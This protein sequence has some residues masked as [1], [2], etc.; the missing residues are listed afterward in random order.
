MTDLAA[1]GLRFDTYGGPEAIRTLDQV[2]DKSGRAETATG[3]LAR[4]QERAAAT[5]R[6]FA[7]ALGL[8]GVGTVAAAILGL[9]TATLEYSGA[10]AEVSTLVD[11]TAVSMGDLS[12][13]AI[14]QAGAFNSSPLLQTQA[15]YQ[16]ISAGAS[17]AATATEQLTAANKLA[18]GGVTTVAIAADGLT[19]I[20][21]AYGPKVAGA[22]AVSDAM[23]VAMRAG[24]TTVEQLS[25]SLGQVS[26][27]AAQVGVS[28]D[29]LAAA[30]A[31][32]T[33][34]GIST[35]VA[36]TGLRAILAAVARPSA[37]AT[38]LAGA[39]GL[40]FNSAALQ[41]KGLSGF[42]ADLN[43]A[44][45]GNV[46]QLGMLFGGVEALV[47]MLALAGTA[48]EDF[49][50][51]MEQMGVKAGA[52]DEAFGKIASG[53]AFQVGRIFSTLGAN[54]LSAGDSIL[55]ILAPAIR[56][57][58]SILQGAYPHAEALNTI[59]GLLGAAMGVVAVRGVI[60]LTSAMT[61]QV[62]AAILASA[63]VRAYAA[64]V[65]LVGPASATA[66]AAVS[67][68]TAT[69]RGAVALMLGPWGIAIA[70]IAAGYLLLK[71]GSD[72]MSAAM[73][74]EISAAGVAGQE[75]MALRTQVI[76]N[77]K[78]KRDLKGAAEGAGEAL[79][80][81]KADADA[82]TTSMT[83]LGIETQ[84]AT[85]KLAEQMLLRAQDE[86]SA[87]EKELA[88]FKN[89]PLYNETTI[90]ART[91]GGRL[92]G[93]VDIAEQNAETAFATAMAAQ[94]AFLSSYSDAA[95]R[96]RAAPV[97]GGTSGGIV[98]AE[99]SRTGKS[100]TEKAIEESTRYLEALRNET[101][102]LGLNSVERRRRQTLMAAEAAPTAELAKAI[103]DAGMAWEMMNLVI[104]ERDRQAAASD[105]GR[106]LAEDARVM[107]LERDLIGATN[108]E[109]AKQIAM[110]QTELDLRSRFGDAFINTSAAQG[111]IGRAGD[112]AAFSEETGQ[113]IRAQNLELEYQV[114]LLRQIADHARD[115]G[116]GLAEAFGEP[117][118]ALGG[119]VS[120]LADMQVKMAEIDEAQRRYV[121]SVGMANVSGEQMAI[122]ARDRAQTEISAY[123]DMA[124]AAK[125][126]F[127]EG[128]DGWK[129]L[130]AIEMGYRLF[131]F[132]AAVQSMVLGNQETASLVAN[133]MT[134]AAASTAAG[135]ARMFE[136]LG[137]L[138]FP[139]VAA[140]LAL[141]AG[142]GLRA[143]GGGRGSA[144][145]AAADPQA[146]VQSSVQT[147]QDSVRRD[148]AT[149]DTFIQRL[150]ASVEV[151]VTSDDPKFRAYIREEA[152]PMVAEGSRQAF[153]ASRRAVPADMAKKQAVTLGIRG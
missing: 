145:G 40:E 85:L 121:E 84:F 74:R 97:G 127:R 50:A 22:T 137:P 78:A 136:F 45:G 87:A 37:E 130:H 122:F 116:R 54:A 150:A 51:I 25:S 101:T 112:N 96:R 120:G 46:E 105:Y 100:E 4:S 128:S 8:L 103:T 10:L 62:T 66:T 23:F 144:P 151:R 106:R 119:L 36:V 76:E 86:Q 43:E 153:Q 70:A 125:G 149:R 134:K 69:V 90:A 72:D 63:T 146:S 9:R 147:A 107:E 118:R 82:L 131:Q 39:L 135:A 3:L 16:I 56:T 139:A 18:V 80:K 83:N 48:G 58:D 152:A 79:Q 89:D 65:A 13:A 17:D 102:E 6:L 67:I 138:G 11:T 61:A 64:S 35:S 104:A 31:A 42:L 29:E 24:K 20:L 26:P 52:T 49:A 32:L 28:F 2:N 27:L 88:T 21:N 81:I 30:T 114:D 141:L 92:E 133:S 12:D 148:Q 1:L 33:K 129:A 117:G 7:G 115:A 94:D 140:M 113:M 71:A 77:A 19:S 126:F 73:A 123:G 109:R 95:A 59:M 142:L 124:S 99:T 5:T 60:A 41:A 47:P 132:S 34:G 44:T 108:V 55:N 75:Y 53:P 111:L 14:R 57:V 91:I 38:K 143:S 15:L 93:R 68:F 98:G 110:L